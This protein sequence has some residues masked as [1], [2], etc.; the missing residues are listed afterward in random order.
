EDRGFV[1]IFFWSRELAQEVFPL[2][3]KALD[4]QPLKPV[5]NNRLIAFRSH[6]IGKGRMLQRV[7]DRFGLKSDEILAV[8]D[9]HNDLCMLEMFHAATTSNADDE[10]KSVV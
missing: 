6:E 5:R 7:S 4:G 8:G 2:F 1:E 10:I 9:S 3:V